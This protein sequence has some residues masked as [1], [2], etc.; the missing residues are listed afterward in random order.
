MGASLLRRACCWRIIRLRRETAIAATRMNKAKK[1]GT[2]TA[3][4]GKEG[5][6]T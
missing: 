1:S 4:T 6:Q 5:F 3:A 2:T